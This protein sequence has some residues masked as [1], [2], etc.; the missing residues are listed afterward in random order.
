MSEI[1]VKEVHVLTRSLERDIQEHIASFESITGC[2]V[3]SVYVCRNDVTDMGSPSR[4]SVLAG[5][6]I[7]TT[8]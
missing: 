1:T 6:E 7:S 2:A 4:K 8:V 3:K 5:I